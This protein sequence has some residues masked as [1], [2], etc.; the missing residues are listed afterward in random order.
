M[1]VLLAT[2]T[3]LLRAY[4]GMRTNEKKARYAAAIGQP[5]PTGIVAGL[6][7]LLRK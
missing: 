1:L 7:G 6:T 3:A 5:V 2:P 4:F